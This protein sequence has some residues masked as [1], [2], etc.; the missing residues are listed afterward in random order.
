MRIVGEEM[1]ETKFNWKNEIKKKL[2]F[3]YNDDWEEKKAKIA[4]RVP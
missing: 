1:I 4:Q 2:L 3:I